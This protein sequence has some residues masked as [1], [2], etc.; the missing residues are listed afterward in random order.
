MSTKHVV[1]LKNDAVGDLVHSLNG[2]YNI[3]NDDNVDK[4]TIF[5]SKFSKKFN[6]L[7]NN[8]KVHIKVINYNLSITEKIK[9]F[10]FILN[11]KIS[12][13]YILAPKNFF[14]YLPIFFF[15]IKF[16]ALCVDNI[17]GYKRPSPFLRKFLYKFVIND[18]AAQ[19]KRLS[20]EK[21]Q[22]K[23]ISGDNA[24]NN[25]F[26]MII[27]KSDL[28][29]KNLPDNYIYFHAKRKIL[30]ELGWG[31]NELKM[32]FNEILKYSDNLILTKDIENDENTKVFKDNFNSFDF[33]TLKFIDNS[34]KVIFFD[35][36]D[37]ADLYNTIINSKK[38]VAFHG[39]MT[40]LASINK[41]KVLDLFHCNIRNWGDYR[42]YRNSFYEFKPS[43]NGYDFII[44]SKNI[45][46]TLKKIRYSLKK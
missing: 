4:I 22:T 39:M 21:I 30:N 16:Y 12:K 11:N 1:I 25:E 42:N 13:I 33:K 5:V 9:L 17:N 6:F 15:N 35:N 27:K 34:Q 28:L 2:I 18:R 31:I 14:Y 36:I 38:V 8:P 40:N 26:S 19:F 24:G 32:L 44:P 7:F 41:H 10:F 45:E 23:L 29:K 37:G 20:T 3:I 46:K 43:Y